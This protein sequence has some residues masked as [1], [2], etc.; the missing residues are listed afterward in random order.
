VIVT[1]CRELTV[2]GAVYRPALVMDPVPAGVMVQFT[3]I[4][5]VPETDAVN[6]CVCP[7]VKVTLTGAT[8]IATGFSVTAADAV[9]VL[10][11]WLVAIRVAVCS[12]VTEVGAV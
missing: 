8:E 11:A 10:S 12:C 9:L 4:F 3:A 2:V 5:A 1:V 7:P 6:C